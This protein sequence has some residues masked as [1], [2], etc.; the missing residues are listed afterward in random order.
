MIL[1]ILKSKQSLYL[2]IIDSKV[3][4]LVS[5][6]RN[7]TIY[8]VRKKVF[9]FYNEMLKD[10][11]VG[12]I[13]D[14]G[15][16]IG[17]LTYYFLKLRYRVFSIEA[18][19]KRFKVLSARFNSYSKFNALNSIVSDEKGII[20]FY[21]NS[22]NGGFSSINRKWVKITEE[23][24]A[25]PSILMQL[26]SNTLNDIIRPYKDIVYLKID[27]EGAEELVLSTLTTPIPIISIE[28]NLPDYRDETLRCIEKINFI[29]SD[30]QYN[31]AINYKLVENNWM[32]YN[33]IMLKVY[34]INES[35]DLFAKIPK[36]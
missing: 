14:V 3:F 15:A 20:D 34:L 5:K 31:Y 6:V 8:K 10:Y 24:F 32:N 35:I 23:K 9:H 30:Y 26:P 7:G 2:K 18:S 22:H 4:G 19:P 16:S 33:E 17:N 11:P 27:V 29:S 28:A 13:I 1:E 25:A 12:T 21:E 36:K